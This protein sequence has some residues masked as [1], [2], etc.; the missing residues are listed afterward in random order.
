MSGISLIASQDTQNQSDAQPS[1]TGQAT[2]GN[3][4]DDDDIE[5]QIKR[6]V[7]SMK[8]RE[9]KAAFQVVYLDIPCRMTEI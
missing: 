6:E 3:H 8:P 9:S 2:S 7:E 4:E 5:A 1:S